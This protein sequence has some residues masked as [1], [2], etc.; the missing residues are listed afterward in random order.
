MLSNVDILIHEAQYMP[1]EYVNKIGW[2]H[3]SIGNACVIAKFA[4]V[5]PWIVV[6][7]DPM[8]SDDFLHDKLNLTQQILQNL[9]CNIQVTH[10]FD[11]KN[12]YF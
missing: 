4:N 11:R 2:G 10:C 6:H 3:S 1:E 12:I 9:D 5:K 8:H 7:H